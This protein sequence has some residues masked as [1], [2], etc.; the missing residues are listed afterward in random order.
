MIDNGMIPEPVQKLNLLDQIKNF[1]MSGIAHTIKSYPF[2]WIEIG[3]CTGIGFLSG[4]LFKKYFK[5]F[6]MTVLFAVLIVAVLDKL[7]LIHIDWQHL[8]STVGIQPTQEAFQN[9][10]Q[11][12]YA[13]M[14]INVQAVTSFGVGF[15]IGYKIV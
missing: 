14:K 2:D 9:L 5:T 8:Q 7:N 13:W 6:I 4:F 12:T 15:I 11:A 1:D 10:F 3:A